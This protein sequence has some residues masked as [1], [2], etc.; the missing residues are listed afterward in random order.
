VAHLSDGTL[1]RMVDDP[2]AM[3]GTESR[4]Y[5]DCP[6]CKARY[7]AQAED[8]VAIAGLLAVPA[9]KVD[10]A[11]AF[12]RVTAAPAAQPRFGLR[13]P[14]WR[15]VS[16]PLV[17]AL[18]AAAVLVALVAAQTLNI[19]S[20]SQVT[21]VPIKLGDLQ[22]LSALSDYGTI[23]WTKEVQPQIVTS[24]AEAAQVS[25]LHVPVVVSLPSGVSST[26]TYAAMPQ[27]EAVFTFSATKAAAAASK[28][29]KS[30]PALPKGMD[31]STL[32]ITVGPAV[33]EIFGQFDT[34]ATSG[35]TPDPTKI[36]LPELFI[37][38]S[39][40][41]VITSTQ[42]SVKQLEDYVASVPGISPELA[43]AL[44]NI[45]DPST[46]L[47][48][49]VPIEYTSSHAQKVQGVNGLAL[50]DNTGAGAAVVWVKSGAVYAVAGFLK[51]DQIVAIAN[52]LS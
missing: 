38:E 35:A 17:A 13:L 23:T 27:A 48:I 22:A 34:G 8:A 11:S 18:A 3:T 32:T 43:S 1:R 15:P 47:P 28:T 37:V 7:A 36:K 46:T 2:D 24:S 10:V 12:K 50:G 14:I 20:P 45:G 52:Q 41:P 6:E 40:A 4:H 39:S 33:G 19:F 30:L 49:P 26:V 44:K 21:P 42:V 29:G 16:R 5:A 9:L 25:G 51:Q 31:G